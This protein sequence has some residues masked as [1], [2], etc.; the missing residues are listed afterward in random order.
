MEL[1]DSIRKIS[2]A[3]SAL[4]LYFT[5]ETV[6]TPFLPEGSKLIG[7]TGQI[8]FCTIDGYQETVFAV[9]NEQGFGLCICPMAYNFSE[10]V[11]LVGGCGSALSAANMGFQISYGRRIAVMKDQNLDL[12]SLRRLLARFSLSPVS[13]PH[14][15]LQTVGQVIDCS[16]VR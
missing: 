7:L 16:R 15:Y 9:R 10:F 1:L 3:E 4:G 2:Y 14:E 13:D 8:Y 12:T 6:Y 11:R 5:R